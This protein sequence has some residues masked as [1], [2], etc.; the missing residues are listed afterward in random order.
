MREATV[1]ARPEHAQ[2][3][4]NLQVG[5]ASRSQ[6][7]AYWPNA[8]S[9][10]EL[11]QSATTAETSPIDRGVHEPMGSKSLPQKDRTQSRKGPQRLKYTS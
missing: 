6:R 2:G 4:P 10:F 8:G 9:L 11:S 1:A 7:I 5:A 3:A